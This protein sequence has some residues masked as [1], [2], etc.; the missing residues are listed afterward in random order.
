MLFTSATF[1]F[2]FLPAVLLLYFTARGTFLRNL[3]L[4]LASVVFYIWGELSHAWI[5]GLLILVNYISAIAIDRCNQPATKRIILLTA[6]AV[7]LAALLR[8]KYAF[9]FTEIWNGLAKDISLPLLAVKQHALPLGISFFVFHCISYLVDIHR[10]R[11]KAQKDPIKMA[12]YIALFPQLIAG[13]IIRFSQICDQFTTR[14]V[15]SEKF[16]LGVRRF[17]IG[18]GKKM[19]LA[20]SFAVPADAIFALDSKFLNP[21]V[22]WLGAIAYTLQLYFDFSGYSDMAIGLA[23]MFGFTFPENFNYPYISQTVR[24]FWQRWHITLSGWFRDYVYIP[25]GGNQHGQARTAANLLIVFLLCG[26]WHGANWTFIAWG[27]FHGFFLSLER[28]GLAS[29]LNRLDQP[30]RHAYTLLVVIVGWVFFRSESLEKAFAHLRAMWTWQPA[31]IGAPELSRFLTSEL[32]VLLFLGAIV[33]TPVL[34]FCKSKTIQFID[35]LLIKTGQTIFL[36]SV[37]CLSI[38]EVS[39]GSYNPFI[40]FHF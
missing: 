30:F 16:A 26:L 23:H 9:F 21:D 40:Y 12:L 32:V 20:N 19:I 38:A 36:L 29:L 35:P 24:E 4:L 18:L 6:C 22:A 15:D 37:L 13:P 11:A 25:M 8:F 39:A 5:I 28:I 7:N 27:L 33:S 17:L 31:A 2:V 3:V 10:G 34:Q 14:Q 1:L